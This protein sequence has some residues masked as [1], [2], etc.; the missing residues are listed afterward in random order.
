M[1]GL[2]SLDSAHGS[3][4]LAVMIEAAIKAAVLIVT[5]LAVHAALGRRRAVVRSALWN[6][7][8]LGLLLLPVASLMLPR[9][10]IF[11][12][13]VGEIAPVQIW[14]RLRRP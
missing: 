4:T 11:V 3:T 7:C 1:S 8:L 10:R 12:P 14:R 5:F 9:L 13:A 2:M 6:T